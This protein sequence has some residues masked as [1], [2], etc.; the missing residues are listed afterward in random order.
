MPLALAVFHSLGTTSGAP[1]RTVARN[2]V[3]FDGLIYTTSR[4]THMDRLDS[5]GPLGR[6]LS[7]TNQWLVHVH[8]QGSM[9]YGLVCPVRANGAVAS[10][11]PVCGEILSAQ[12]GRTK[13]KY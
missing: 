5:P 12:Q 8:L 6:L 1:N 9:A 2:P 13:R 10:C 3:V 7:S 11:G 4:K